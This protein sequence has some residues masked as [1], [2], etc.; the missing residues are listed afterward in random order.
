MTT[1][2]IILKG[3]NLHR[4]NLLC[5]AG[6]NDREFKAQLDEFLKSD[7]KKAYC[8]DDYIDNY[9]N[10]L[11]YIEQERAICTDLI[12][13]MWNIYI[14]MADQSEKEHLEKFE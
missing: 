7:I 9:Y 3:E 5:N 12:T 6:L 1:K 2:K 4:F 10:L 11:E 13:Y 14:L 8:V